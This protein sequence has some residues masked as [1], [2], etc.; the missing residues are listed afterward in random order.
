MLCFSEK[1][2]SDY[3]DGVFIGKVKTQMHINNN[4]RMILINYLQT[5]EMNVLTV[6]YKLD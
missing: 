3:D 2:S 5:L 6:K 1:K 4:F